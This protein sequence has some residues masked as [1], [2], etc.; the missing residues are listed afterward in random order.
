MIRLCCVLLVLLLSACAS[1]VSPTYVG[2][3]LMLPRIEQ[4]KQ[5]QLF[6]KNEGMYRAS[7]WQKPGERWADTFAVT[8]A[9]IDDESLLDKRIKMD[10]PGRQQCQQFVSRVLPHPKIEGYAYLF[11]HTECIVDNQ[12]RTQLMHLMILGDERFYHLQKAW[13]NA[14]DEQTF[15]QWK[16]YFEQT[17]V[18][19]LQKQ[20]QQQCSLEVE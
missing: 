2:E 20:T 11:W 18:C 1:Q 10:L 19:N 17:F 13:R 6:N 5:W 12:P 4:L 8:I 9:A 16:H 7:M 15:L 14:V 3:N